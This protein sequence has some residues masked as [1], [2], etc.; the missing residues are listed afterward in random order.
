MSRKVPQCWQDEVWLAVLD[1]KR[2]AI[3]YA[4]KARQVA[5]AAPDFLRLHAHLFYKTPVER[6]DE[7]YEKLPEPEWLV[8]DVDGTTVYALRRSPPPPG[9]LRVR[10]YPS[11]DRLNMEVYLVDDFPLG[12]DGEFDLKQVRERWNLE[13]C[14][15]IDCL[16]GILVHPRDPDRL[17]PL[18]L[19]LLVDGRRCLRIVEQP[20]KEIEM[21]REARTKIRKEIKYRIWL[22]REK[23]RK[24]R[25]AIEEAYDWW[26]Q[27]PL[28]RTSD[29]FWL[30]LVW[31]LFI[32]SV[33]QSG[34]YMCYAAY[35]ICCGA[36]FGI[37][38]IAEPLSQAYTSSDRPA[39]FISRTGA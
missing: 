3:E 9:T 26:R 37:Q 11:V 16:R 21:V 30:F 39:A 20:S 6:G 27:H 34:Y 35:F 19:Q 2:N 12:A 22:V 38:H 24:S 32:A 5:D 31:I 13:N 28:P 1:M 25:L 7:L 18:A 33:A 29:I 10:W 15:P 8:V 14:I 36:L 23:C 17:S 4:R